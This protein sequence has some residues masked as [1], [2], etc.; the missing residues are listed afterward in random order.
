MFVM[1]FSSGFALSLLSFRVFV[2]WY[3]WGGNVFFR[4]CLFCVSFLSGNRIWKCPFM[5]IV[6]FYDLY[7]FLVDELSPRL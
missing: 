7:W 1:C 4:A 5:S 6:I 3:V 2:Y